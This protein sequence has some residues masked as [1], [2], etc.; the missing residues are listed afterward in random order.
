M[1]SASVQISRLASRS[2]ALVSNRRVG[3]KQE[4]GASKIPIASR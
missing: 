1:D 3:R 2:G 4:I